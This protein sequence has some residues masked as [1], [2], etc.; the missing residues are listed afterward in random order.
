MLVLG[1]KRNEAILIGNGIEII[2]TEIS[3]GR[4]RLGIIAPVDV[5][6]IR[7]ELKDEQEEPANGS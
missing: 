6:V 5:K 7:A 1:R 4:V 3:A 2:V